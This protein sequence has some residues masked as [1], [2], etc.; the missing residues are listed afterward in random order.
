MNNL[1]V[2]ARQQHVTTTCAAA[3]C[4]NVHE[5]HFYVLNTTVLMSG[6]MYT[7]T[8]GPMQ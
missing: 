1:L 3:S 8:W 5:F 4:V 2:G 6:I 7:W